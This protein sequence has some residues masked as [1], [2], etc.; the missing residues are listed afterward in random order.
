MKKAT[1][2]VYGEN[3]RVVREWSSIGEVGCLYVFRLEDIYTRNENSLYPLL[4]NVHPF[5]GHE[6]GPLQI[7][8]DTPEKLRQRLKAMLAALDKPTLELT[9][10]KLVEIPRSPK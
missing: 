4:P 10:P 9:Q 7:M 2:Y 6:G 5:V 3:W 8:G 1:N